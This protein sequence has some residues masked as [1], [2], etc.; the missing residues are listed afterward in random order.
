MLLEE[1]KTFYL[2]Y[3]DYINSKL[4][5]TFDKEKGI[6]IICKKNSFIKKGELV[7]VEKALVSKKDEEN[8][9]KRKILGLNIYD[10]DNFKKE[11][12]YQN[13]EMTNELMEKIKKYK[14]DYEIFFILYDG[15]NKNL[16]IEER[17]NKYLNG[18]EKRIGFE[19]VK[20][21]I[22][23]SKY[24]AMRNIFFQNKKG[25]GLWGYTSILNHSCN[26]NINNFSIGDFM[27]CFATKGI[28]GGEELNT[29]YINNSSC[30]SLRQ[31]KCINNWGFS[32]SCDICIYDKNNINNSY[33]KYYED[34]F[35]EFYK[36]RND[37]L[38]HKEK[39]EKYLLFEKFLDENKNRLSS[40]ESINGYLQLIYHYGI[41]NNYNKCKEISEII[42][43]ITE[44]ENYY[45]FE[46]EN[47]N[48]IFNFFGYKDKIVFNYLI[49]RY[50]IFVRKNIPIKEDEFKELIKLT[51]K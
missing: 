25:F 51:L 30:F 12:P 38:F 32:C 37:I 47:L 39:N 44:K 43:D 45:S 35:E 41:L 6:K 5:I 31:S 15:D 40:F 29:L 42:S 18:E 22:D 8:I 24:S 19:K 48:M 49:K 34:S 17:K 33:K 7:I 13:L 1:E 27:I 2:T 20:K 14:E 9:D 23:S 4:E 26:P 10:E 16:N 11:E 50:E 46:L 3:E 21:I 28:S 36:N